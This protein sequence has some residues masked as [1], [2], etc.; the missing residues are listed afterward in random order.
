M[1]EA[2][3][4]W[5]L[6]HLFSE[7]D[8]RCDDHPHNLEKWYKAKRADEAGAFFPYL[9]ESA[10]KITKFYTLSADTDGKDAAILESADLESL[11][12]S[13]SAV[14]P[15]SKPSGPN[16]AQL[17]SV[18]K[19]AYDK[20]KGPMPG[21]K[22]LGR[23]LDAF[24]EISETNKP[25]SGFF[26]E[27][28][29][30]WE[31]PKVRFAGKMLDADGNALHQA[32]AAVPETQ[33]TV[34][35]AYK[36]PDGTLPGDVPEYAQYLQEVLA[37]TKYATKS[38][39]PTDHGVCPLCGDSAKL[40]PAACSGAGINI[41][42]MDRAGAFPG[43]NKA[44]SHLGY[45]LCLD[46][47]DLL[48]V[49]HFYVERSLLAPVAGKHA[50]VLPHLHS[51][52]RSLRR[53]VKF[54]KDYIESLCQGQ[55]RTD[56]EERRLPQM[57]GDARVVGT[58]DIIWADFGNKMENIRGQILEILPTR[59][60]DL[61]K[62]NNGFDAKKPVVAPNYWNEELFRFDLN[63]SFLKT[64]FSRPGGK[65][66]QK[67]NDSARLM[68]VKRGM[69]A[70]IY[71]GDPFPDNRA[72]DEL[73]LTAQWYL[74]QIVE[75]KADEHGLLYEGYSEKKKTKWMTMAG[76]IKHLAVCLHYLDLLK[77]KTR[78]TNMRTFEPETEKLRPL[79]EDA[80]GI[81]SNEKAFAFMLGLLLGR[82]MFIQSMKGISVAANALTWL[83]RLNLSGA[84]MPEVL[85]KTRGKLLQYE[86][87][88]DTAKFLNKT[89][90]GAMADISRLG[91]MIG[92][93]PS[94]NKRSTCYFILLGQALS[95]QVFKKEETDTKDDTN[96]PGG[97]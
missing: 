16:A 41:C 33:D 82:V 44:N 63:L 65:S 75:G 62:F 66:A 84:D 5:G 68:E 50:L 78:E 7:L 13:S 88:S 96:N 11:S 86:S 43:V 59:F 18:L 77:I 3:R 53:T 46:C 42:N 17:G 67:A 79:F 58:I 34:F 23:T 36:R 29:D 8:G 61:D 52:T 26:R 1:L 35:F 55:A 37:E 74:R 94:L 91:T 76:W 20:N 56:I 40:F 72:W 39:M 22:I 81:D 73:L 6:C 21:T 45:A 12:K 9:V 32:I 14:L 70:A 69:A 87:D 4:Q 49:F 89:V 51:E 47:A 54:Y 57:L 31:R 30:V 92:D 48:Y 19:R 93:S 38:A 28:L 24:R 10:G 64:L 97:K 60:R 15:F 90:Y 83:K 25:W 71:R 2:M 27:V 85:N 80:T 95:T